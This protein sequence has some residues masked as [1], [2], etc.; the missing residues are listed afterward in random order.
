[1]LSPFLW[2][3]VRRALVH[4]EKSLTKK[5]RM[6]RTPE[7]CGREIKKAADINFVAAD[8]FFGLFVLATRK[9]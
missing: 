3:S 2:G 9:F 8:S 4:L 6:P 1:V 5:N 7:N